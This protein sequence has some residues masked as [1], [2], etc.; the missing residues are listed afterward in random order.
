MTN[1][2]VKKFKSLL[3]KKERIYEFAVFKLNKITS[4]VKSNISP[5]IQPK[6]ARIKKLKED[7]ASVFHDDLPKSLPPVQDVD[8]E[9]ELQPDCK[10]PNWPIF[11]LSPVALQA[12]KE[13][14]IDLFQKEKTKPSKYLF[15]APLFF[16][17]QKGQIRGVIDYYGLDRITKSNIVPIR[18]TNEMFDRVNNAKFHSALDL[19]TGFHQSWIFPRGTEKTTSRTKYGNF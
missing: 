13:Y 3:R 17:K 16:V 6:E 5:E 14:V 11:L 19:K 1:L 7:F 2:Q 15:G 10:P 9:V 8:Y 12:T 4:L 18:W